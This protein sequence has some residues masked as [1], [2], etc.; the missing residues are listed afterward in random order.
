MSTA[1]NTQKEL[2]PYTAKAQTDNLTPQ[3]KVDGLHSIVKH[4]KTGM[5]T[6]RDANG[7]MHSRAM[8]PAGRKNFSSSVSSG[9]YNLIFPSRTAFSSHQ[10]DLVFIANRASHKF[11]ELENDAH[12]NVSFYDEGSTSW[13]SYCGTARITQDKD[14]I[15][16]HWGV[17]YVL[18]VLT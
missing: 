16:K 13:A 15:A 18:L 4:V 1:E 5:L 6:T 17:A 10:V 12:V 3:Q 9:A 2:D 11:D 7:F 8:S 14:K